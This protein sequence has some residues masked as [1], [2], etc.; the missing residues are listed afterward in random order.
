MFSDL[1][2]LGK[3]NRIGPFTCAYF[4]SQVAAEREKAQQEEAAAQAK[5]TVAPKKEPPTPKTYRQGVGK[6]INLAVT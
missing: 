5:V 2:G 6:Y 1:G 3:W 4:S